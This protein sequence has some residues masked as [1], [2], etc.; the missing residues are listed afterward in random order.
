[1]VTGSVRQEIGHFIVGRCRKRGYEQGK[2]ELGVF[3]GQQ[4]TAGRKESPTNE[5]TEASE[6]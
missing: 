5:L 1:M 6:L 2:R 4:A 3:R